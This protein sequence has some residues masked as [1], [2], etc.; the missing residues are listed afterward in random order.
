MLQRPLEAGASYL[1][2]SEAEDESGLLAAVV[3]PSEVL[4]VDANALFARLGGATSPDLSLIRGPTHT[5]SVG[6]R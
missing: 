5:Q 1:L 6:P 2:F 4:G 3:G